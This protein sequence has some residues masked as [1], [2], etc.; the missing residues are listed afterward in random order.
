MHVACG[1]DQGEQRDEAHDGGRPRVALHDAAPT[2]GQRPS[3]AG[4]LAVHERQAQPVDLRSD[5]PE[6]GRQQRHR[7]QHHDKHRGHGPD[8]KA[9]EKPEVHHE[10][11][12][13]R[14]DHRAT[15][16]DHRAPGGGDRRY[17]GSPRLE[18]RVQR[19]AVAGDDEEHVVDP[20]ADADHRGHLRREVGHL[21]QVGQERD[22][23][24]ADAE[25]D[26]RDEDRQAHGQQRAEAD[27]QDQRRNQEADALGA[28]L[29]L[30]GTVERETGQLDLEVR[31]IELP[32]QCDERLGVGFLVVGDGLVE[33]KRA[34]GDGAL[35]RDLPGALRRER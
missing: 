25:A 4:L 35:R 11:A 3:V 31:P 32:A 1:R 28:E 20:D 14:D 24:Q 18:P 33:A 21:E 27:E 9:A 19:G 30:L 15:G 17:D 22:Q 10:Q 2:V 12:E 5:E 13:E 7:R 23:A 16:E 26:D 8:R 34:V 6:H 29:G